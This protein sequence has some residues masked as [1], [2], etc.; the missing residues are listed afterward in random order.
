VVALLEVCVSDPNQKT[1]LKE[2][3]T[4]NETTVNSDSSIV[5]GMYATRAAGRIH[6]F[7]LLFED[8]KLL[9]AKIVEESNIINVTVQLLAAI[10]A[11]PHKLIC[12]TTK[13]G[14]Q[15]H[16]SQKTVQV[17]NSITPKWMTPMLLF[18]DLH[19]K[20][21]LGMNRRDALRSLCSHNWKWFDLS[22]GKWTSYTLPNNKTID[23]AFWA[24]E[25]SV[26]I[27]NSR[28]KYSIQFGTMMQTNE[29]NGQSSSG[30][31]ILVRS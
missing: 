7:T 28:R 6:L 1:S 23:D 21:I 31:D 13:T 20:V 17:G 9:C 8:C 26:R 15:T 27:Q 3:C 29:G 11:N 24:G 12:E 5:N 18:I 22:N 14:T 4:P 2:E 19:E 16:V 10:Q 25:A 30:N